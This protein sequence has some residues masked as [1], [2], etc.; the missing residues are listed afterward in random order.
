MRRFLPLIFAAALQTANVQAGTPIGYSNG[1]CG[2]NNIFRTGSTTKQG[3]AIKMAKGKLQNLKGHTISGIEAA[4]GTRNTIDHIAK[5]FVATSPDATPLAEA[6]G[7]IDRAA[8][9]LT[10]NL[11]T[12]YTITGDEDELY[13]GYVVETEDTKTYPLSCD[14]SA[15][16]EGCCYIYSDGKWV[17]MYGMGVGSP[18]VRA[19]VD[20]VPAFTDL[21]LKTMNISGYYKQ[22]EAYIFGTQLFNFGT[23]DVNSFDMVLKVGD[24]EPQ[25]FSYTDKIPAGGVFDIKLP[26]Y[27]ATT[28]GDLAI[29]LEVK[30]INGSDDA[31]T[32][33]NI[34][35]PSVFFYPEN[36]ERSL[37]L[38]G[39]TGQDCP[40]C[41]NGHININKFLAS[42]D[43]PVI[44]VMHH[45]GYQPDIFSTEEDYDYTFF[46]GSGQTY[47]PS[48]M[49]N[50]TTFPNLGSVPVMN[51]GVEFMT[52]AA[53][54]AWNNYQPYVS[55]KLESDYNNTTR[56]VN[57]KATIVGHTALPEGQSILN[58]ALIQ[59]GIVARQ[60]AGGNEYVHDNVFREALT[61]N[62]WGVL[63]PDNFTGGSTTSWSKTFTL[64]E[65]IFSS[66]YNNEANLTAK[67]FT[68]E[69][70]T[71]ATDPD[72]MY[73]VAYVGGYDINNPNKHTV[74]NCVKVKLG[75]S[76][77]QG[78]VTA[79][80][81]L[82]VSKGNEPKIS[83]NGRMINVV[84]DYDTYYIYNVSGQK[85]PTTNMLNPGMY[86]VQVKN[87]V[88]T[89]VKKVIVK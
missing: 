18:N 57:V 73:L 40:N 39:F 85:V 9:W 42:T 14:Y 19:L 2:R 36:M 64:P 47:A 45:S 49:M 76:Y 44:E 15:D 34:T 53:D 59:N 24:A 27:T 38:E 33:D 68:K 82:P 25:T 1:D 71:I 84:G 81:P 55:L 70:V 88:K 29:S 51:T 50:R 10:F 23:A 60:S 62:S 80:S 20:D 17:D 41:P 16:T 77:E 65:G 66:F 46:Y 3:V 5:V 78:G 54:A 13:I 7:T 22:G 48:F 32:D 52:A 4:F 12:P 89:T 21:T 8:K 75:E 69:D 86:I 87:G 72:K 67:G 43:K 37:L 31:D 6:S 58:V 63:L 35:T 74:Y 61:G 30:N 56:E 11:D 26:E 28:S 83:V 79:I